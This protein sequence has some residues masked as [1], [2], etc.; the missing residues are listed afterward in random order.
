MNSNFDVV[1]IGAGAAGL[2]CAI[3]A[4][5]RNKKVLIIEHSSKIAEKIRISGRGF[6]IDDKES[7]LYF[8][9]RPRKSQL[10]AWASKQ[11]SVIKS[12]KVL[13]NRFQK[14]EKKFENNQ[15]TRPPY[16]VGI[17]I[18]PKTFE[19]WQGDQFRLHE[20]ELFYLKK[21]V[22]QKKVLSP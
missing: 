4:G 2:M 14:Y 8:S 20:R 9:S 12:R 21:K 19:F 7:D 13:I 18:V 10:G 1:V 22:W 17:K 3:E 11:S 16:W 15:V 5:K 6:I